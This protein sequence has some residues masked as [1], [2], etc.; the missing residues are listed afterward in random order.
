MYSDSDLSSLYNFL[1][2]TGEGNLR[3]MLVSGAMTENHFRIMLKVVRAAS[4]SEFIQCAN[5]GAWPKIKLTESER[6]AKE[7]LW[8]VALAACTN[9]GLISTQKAA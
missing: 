5:G 9:V 4:E 3:K 1:K 7:G 2:S 8:N 6:P